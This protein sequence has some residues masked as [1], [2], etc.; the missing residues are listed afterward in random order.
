MSAPRK[1]KP[2]NPMLRSLP[3]AESATA[4]SQSSAA[5]AAQSIEEALERS[6]IVAG[7][8]AAAAFAAAA[9]LA[10]AAD[11][12][13]LDEPALRAPLVEPPSSFVERAPVAP[14]NDASRPVASEHPVE[15]PIA[16]AIN[17]FQRL[18]LNAFRDAVDAHFNFA[19]GHG[20]GADAVRC[21][22]ASGRS[23]A[24]A[25]RRGRRPMEK[26]DAGRANFSR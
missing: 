5:L 10:R 17:D 22:G 25:V 19:T 18:T 7:D 2:F 8:I 11:D 4:L 1:Q 13:R 9:P 6:P 12:L 14:Q 3:G 26:L 24:P 23:H 16:N 21:G 15:P 20:A